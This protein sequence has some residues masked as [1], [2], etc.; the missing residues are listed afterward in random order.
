MLERAR[1]SG[2]TRT[3]VRRGRARRARARAR[4]RVM[5]ETSSSAAASASGR[6]G[7]DQ[8]AGCARVD[9]FRNSADRGCD[10]RK[11]RGHCFEDA[12]RARF[13]SR[14]Q[15][16]HVARRQQ[17]RDVAPFAEKLDVCADARR[18]SHGFGVLPAAGRLRRMTNS[19][20]GRRLDEPARQ[21]QSRAVVA[22]FG[23]QV[24]DGDH[25]TPRPRRTGARRR[26]R[27]QSTPFGIVRTFRAGTPSRASC[28][29]AAV[30][31]ATTACAAPIGEPLA[32]QSC[33]ARLVRRQ[34]LAPVADAH[35]DAG[36]SGRRAGRRCSS[37]ARRYGRRAPDPAAPRGKR[38]RLPQR[39][40]AGRNPPIGNTSIEVTLLGDPASQRPRR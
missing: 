10:D 3:A 33:A 25:A 9:Q 38:Q 1:P 17:R 18:A 26:R 15:H 27:S 36:E 4:A 8:D 11:A 6:S 21:R 31:F 37:R 29:A 39:R 5:H 7:V 30:E 12:V 32:A 2:R 23:P 19:V 20:S 40:R 24:G 14:R 13:G 28:A 35:V 16:E 22:F 34:N